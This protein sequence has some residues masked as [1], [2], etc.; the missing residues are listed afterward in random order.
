MTRGLNEMTRL[1][2]ALGAQ[3]LTFLGLAGLGDLILTCTGDLSR[4]RTMGLELAQGKTR[5]TILGKR[6]AVTEGVATAEAV[7]RLS[8]KLSLDLPI[9]EEIY[10]VLYKDKSCADAIASL[11]SRGL[12]H[13]FQDLL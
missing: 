12:K 2:Q 3:P 6:K 11:A 10:Q 13:E 5:E 9:C 1:G 4:N 8:E 7:H